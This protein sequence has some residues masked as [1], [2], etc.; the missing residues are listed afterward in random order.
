MREI[1]HF[2]D[3]CKK[4]LQ[5]REPKRYEAGRAVTE[6]NGVRITL[7][8]S[9]NGWGRRADIIPEF[10]SEDVCDDCYNSF[11]VKARKFWTSLHV[12]AELKS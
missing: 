11:H 2:C 3:F 10:S 8:Y 1:R 9:P 5:I 6:K 12:K 4:E 7:G